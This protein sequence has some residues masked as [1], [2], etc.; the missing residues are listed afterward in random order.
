[1]S[2]KRK[3]VFALSL[4][5]IVGLCMAVRPVTKQI[6]FYTT[7]LVVRDDGYLKFGSDEDVAMNVWTPTTAAAV[8]ADQPVLSDAYPEQLTGTSQYL[9]ANQ[10]GQ[11]FVTSTQASTIYLPDAVVGMD[12]TLKVGTSTNQKVEPCGPDRINILTNAAGDSVTNGTAGGILRLICVTADT[13]DAF[14][15]YGTWTDTN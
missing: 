8:R 9:R 1:M 5:I 4:L 6:W 15:V 12:Y 7:K 14:I 2:K 3:L 11:V 10:S 13:W